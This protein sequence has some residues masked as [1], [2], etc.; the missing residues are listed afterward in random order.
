MFINVVRQAGQASDKTHPYKL[1]KIRIQANM[2][3]N[4]FFFMDACF[5]ID[6]F[7]LYFLDLE[8]S[9]YV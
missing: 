9:L 5:G 7:I 1:N 2:I 3:D 8:L 6:G 4:Y